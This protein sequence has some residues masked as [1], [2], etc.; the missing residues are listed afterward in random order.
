[1]FGY[2]P[3][4][5]MSLVWTT[6]TLIPL[7]D[8][9]SSYIL[10]IKYMYVHPNFL[11]APAE[12]AVARLIWFANGKTNWICDLALRHKKWWLGCQKLK[13]TPGI[14]TM[15]SSDLFPLN[16][17]F[18]MVDNPKGAMD[19]WP[20]KPQMGEFIFGLTHRLG[21]IPLVQHTGVSNS[22]RLHQSQIYP[23]LNY[24]IHLFHMKRN[25]TIHIPIS[26]WNILY[27][28]PWLFW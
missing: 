22:I 13:L 28:P 4:A 17:D 24:K 14:K 11:A 15:V 3:W 16:L 1:M 21:W 27:C 23:P 6:Y 20:V 26:P 2:L 10:V 19:I 18:Q 12:L 9:C 25:R 5:S 7:H 8:V